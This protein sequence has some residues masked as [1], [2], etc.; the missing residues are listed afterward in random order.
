[1]KRVMCFFY[2]KNSIGVSDMDD[3]VN[4][5]RQTNHHANYYAIKNILIKLSIKGDVH[6][7]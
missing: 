2:H 3:D 5:Y 1:M 7:K 6:E 4:F